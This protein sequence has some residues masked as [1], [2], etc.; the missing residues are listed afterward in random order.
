MK[1]FKFFI[2]KI[3]LRRAI[4]SVS[5]LA[6]IFMANYISFVA[7]RSVFSTLEGYQEIKRIDQKG[8]FIANLDPNSDINMDAIS[9]KKIQ[10]VYN[11]LS[12]NFKF[13]LYTDGFSIDLKNDYDMD[14]SLSYMNEAYYKLNTFELSAGRNLNF[15]YQ[16][17]GGE[18]IPVLI[19][20]GLSK[21]YPLGSVIKIKDPVLE[22]TVNLKVQGILK[23]NLSHSNFYALNSKQYYN[24]TIFVPMNDEFIKNSNTDLKLNGL[25]D[26]I[27]LKTSKTEVSNLKEVIHDNLNLKFNFYSQKDNFEYFNEYFL[28]SLKFISLI[29]FVLLVVVT[30]L[31][32]WSALIGIRLMLREFTINLLVGLSYSKLRKMFYSYYGILFFVNLVLLFLIT[33]YSRY[34]SWIRKDSFFAT[35]GILGLI[36]MDWLALLIVLFSDI[37]IGTII[38]EIIIKRI[39]KVPI[40]LGVLQ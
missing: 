1:I 3:F 38:I 23:S 31:S 33:A 36:E 10:T 13:A 27:I 2:T 37:I 20:K 34:G 25:M 12:D 21:T 5:I 22:K 32:V 28:S 6:L 17:D 35:Y 15:K 4:L 18:A 14:V 11:F 40:S 9:K 24:F 29:T 30:C 26:L 19:G 7:A 16:F 8:N 39:K